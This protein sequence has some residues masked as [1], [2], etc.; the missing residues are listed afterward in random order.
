MNKASFSIESTD[1]SRD[2]PRENAQL[3][4]I[5]TSLSENPGHSFFAVHLNV[6]P[7]SL[8]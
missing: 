7:P 8:S 1:R 3:A 5:C 6:P 4:G 2:Y